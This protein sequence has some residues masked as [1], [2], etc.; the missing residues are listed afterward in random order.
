MDVDTVIAKMSEAQKRALISAEGT[1]AER[2]RIGFPPELFGPSWAG[3]AH[4]SPLGLAVRARLQE[5]ANG[6]S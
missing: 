4:F 2:E 1:W 6:H 3:F 5:Q